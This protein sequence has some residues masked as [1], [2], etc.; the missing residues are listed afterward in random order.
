[1]FSS[2]EEGNEL[3]S[4][5]DEE[6][7]YSSQLS[8]S[9]PR[10][11]ERKR[12]REEVIAVILEEEKLEFDEIPL[13]V[14]EMIVTYIDV[15]E[16]LTMTH[17]YKTVAKLDRRES[18]WK[19]FFA[20][21]M[22]H[23]YRV[24]EGKM[25]NFVTSFNKNSPPRWKRLYLYLRLKY[26]RWVRRSWLMRTIDLFLKSNPRANDLRRALATLFDEDG[27]ARFD[28]YD[29]EK[30]EMMDIDK[31]LAN[32]LGDV[33]TTK[34]IFGSNTHLLSDLR[35]ECA[36]M[37]PF[38]VC[39]TLYHLPD[40]N[41]YPYRNMDFSAGKKM[42]QMHEERS[43]WMTFKHRKDIAKLL[44]GDD[45]DVNNDELERELWLDVATVA[46]SKEGGMLIVASQI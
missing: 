35:E 9:I 21:D 10:A 26:V 40:S 16:F 27:A 42:R 19:G 39:Y 41:H 22:P 46:R 34:G 29:K 18:T 4:T 45:R 25:P 12:S 20:R 17:K 7:E 43:I 28:N 32:A 5:V 15:R 31:A 44:Q 33:E 30:P 3:L 37:C 1:M 14:Q 6:E 13:R 23:E 38:E 36:N 24:L 2:S 11:V 8:E